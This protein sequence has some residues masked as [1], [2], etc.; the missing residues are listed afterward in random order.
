MDAIAD[1][2]DSSELNFIQRSIQTMSPSMETGFSLPNFLWEFGEIKSLGKWWDRGKGVFRNLSN[3]TLN[4]NFGL[5]PFIS[6]VR[7]LAEGLRTLQSRLRSLKSQAGT[8]C[9]RHYRETCD[10]STEIPEVGGTHIWRNRA[11]ISAQVV[12]NATMSYTYQFPNLDALDSAI[13]GFLDSI[14]MQLSAATVWEAIPYSFVVDWF[15]NVGDFLKQFEKSWIDIEINIVDYCLST[16]IEGRC[17]TET[18]LYKSDESCSE[19]SPNTL[20][21]F[22]S[23]RR[24]RM[25][26]SD[27]IFWPEMLGELTLRK[28]ILGALLIEQ[29]GTPLVRNLPKRIRNF[30]RL[31]RTYTE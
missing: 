20:R 4:Y 13:Y 21:N 10:V 7:S 11:S 16:R 8:L 24:R 18:R 6:D 9:R 14:G 28:I 3:G 30:K 5:K 2:L 29:R 19:W 1:E 25:D 22:K 23:Y 31:L 26:V 15:F 27:T 17:V 12:R